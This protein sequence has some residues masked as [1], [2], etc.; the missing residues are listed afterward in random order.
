MSQVAQ[1]TIIISHQSSKKVRCGNKHWSFEFI[2]HRHA[3]L[4]IMIAPLSHGQKSPAG[5]I[6][7]LNFMVD[8]TH[9]VRHMGL[10]QSY[11]PPF[12]WY[13]KQRMQPGSLKYPGGFTNFYAPCS[14]QSP[15]LR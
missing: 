1:H 9:L 14:I 12:V 5:R 11:F 13:H 10:A 6:F 3:I 8:H 2:R 4:K 7:L 15:Y